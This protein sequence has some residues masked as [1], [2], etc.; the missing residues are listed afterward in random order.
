LLFVCSFGI[1]VGKLPVSET[2]GAT[3]APTAPEAYILGP[4]DQI[5]VRVFHADEF[6]DKPVQIGSDGFITLPFLGD[7]KAAGLTVR[8]LER[9][10]SNDLSKYLRNPQITI[11][12]SDYRSQPVSMLGAFNTP[13]VQQVKGAKTLLQMIA[14]AGGLRA[15]AGNQATIVRQ[16]QWGMIPI[17][18]AHYDD[19]GGASVAVIN[20]KELLSAKDSAKD[21]TIRPN[22]TVSVPRS[23]LIYVTGEV[24]RAGGFPLQEADSLS[25]MQA[26]ALAGGMTRTAAPKRARILRSEPGRPDRKEIVIDVRKVAEGTAPD[27]ALV[28]EDILFIPNNVPKSAAI[29]AAEAAVQ[30]GTGIA[31]FH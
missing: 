20:L 7:V 6:S 8:Q 18:T 4:E 21:I 1:A 25:V 2:N 24:V 23:S 12:I 29:R 17:P 19:S 9:N 10:L 5:L 11:T 28:A 14:L 13:G 27:V 15:D 31:I 3:I 22:D 16:K 30:I 26:L